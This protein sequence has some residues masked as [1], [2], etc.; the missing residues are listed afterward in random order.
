AALELG[1][2]VMVYG[3]A[4]G[5]THTEEGRT[6][7]TGERARAAADRVPLGRVLEAHEVAAAAIDLV[8]GRYPAMTGQI[9]RLDGGWS[10]SDVELE[11]L[12]P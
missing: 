9:L 1:P 8:T 11:R 2:T 10:S 7:L 12:T 4:A 3:L 6:R 5:Y